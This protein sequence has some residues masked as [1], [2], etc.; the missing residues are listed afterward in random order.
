[1]IL[2]SKADH[3]NSKMTMGTFHEFAMPVVVDGRIGGVS[4]IH[5][6]AIDAAC[7]SRAI[8]LLATARAKHRY[9]FRRIQR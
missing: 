7:R 3:G 4:R 5:C 2:V 9:D 8:Q 1:V 6:F